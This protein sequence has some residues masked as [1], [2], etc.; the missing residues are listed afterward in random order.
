MHGKTPY[1][2]RD[3]KIAL[4]CALPLEA[5]CVQEVFDKFWEDEGKTYGKAPG[6][7]NVYTAGVIGEHNVVLAYMPGM[8]TISA[9]AAAGSLRVS[10]PNITLAL[11][12]GI[13]GGIPYDSDQEETVLGDVIVSQALI[14]YDIGRQYPGGFKRKTDIRD[15]LG[16]P[17]PEIRAL[18][19][20]LR[21]HRYKQRMQNNITTFLAEIQRELPK[22]KYPGQ[23]NDVLYHSLYIHQHHPPATCN[24]CGKDE[25]ICTL[26]SE[27]ACED[28]RCESH[29]LVTRTRLMSTSI[30]QPTVHFGIMGSG[31]TVMK[32]GQHRDQ[33]A[34]ADG[35]IGFEMEG[36][37][38]WDYFPSIV[39]KGVCDYA[40]SHKRKGWQLYAAATAAACAKAFL[41]EWSV[42]EAPTSS[43]P[44]PQWSVPLERNRDFVERGDMMDWLLERIS[45]DIDK[46][47]CQQTAIEGL[48]GVGKTQMALEAAF[49]FRDRYPECSVFWVT[50]VDIAS[51]ENAYRN[52]GKKLALEGI[53]DNQA[54]VK[55][56]V[57]NAMSQE[58][59]GSWLLIVDN[60]DDMELFF[61]T[62]ALCNY[63]P[64]S[65]QGSILFTSRNHEVVAELDIPQRNIVTITEMTGSEAIQMLRTNLNESQIRDSDSTTALLE[66]LTHLPLAIKQASAYMAKT[67]MSTA[68]Y[69]QHCRS[70]DER[71]IMLLSRETEYQG[72]YKGMN[73]A[74]ATTWLISFNQILRDKPLAADILRHIC[75]LVDKD[76]PLSLF[77][78]GHDELELDEAI[79]T[80]KAYA[81]ITEREDELSFDVHRL[82]QLAMRHWLQEEGQQKQWIAKTVQQ[83]ADIF[84]FPKHENRHL[85]LRYL[86][87]A[88]TAAGFQ[89]V[90][91]IKEEADID[92]IFKI[93][94]SYARLGKHGEAVPRYQLVLDLRTKV[95]GERHF[96]TLVSMNNLA[97]ALE[98]QEEYKEAE[99]IYQRVIDLQK[100]VLEEHLLFLDCPDRFRLAEAL[101]N[102]GRHVLEEQV[103]R[104]VL[105]LKER[106]LRLWRSLILKTMNNLAVIFQ[107]Q[108]KPEEAERM[109]QQILD[110]TEKTLG[111]EHHDTLIS[112]NNLGTV[113]WRQGKLHEAEQILRQT[114]N[115][116][117]KVLGEESVPTLTV[118]NNL[119][120]ILQSQEKYNE[121]EQIRRQVLSLMKEVLGEVHHDTL[122]A[123]DHLG[124]A[125]WLG[126]KHQEA[127]QMLRQTLNL[128]KEVHGQESYS[129]L[130][131]MNNLAEIL[132]SQEKYNEAEQIRRPALS[133]MKKV[134]G[135]EHCDTLVGMNNLIIVLQRQG[136]DEEAQRIK[137]SLPC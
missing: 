11:V 85:W 116:M 56:L 110:E 86:P 46:D 89:D 10:F 44:Q 52:I 103:Q 23:E 112:M 24:E 76:I 128:M 61:G 19:A 125:L 29:M 78:Q 123:M 107:K 75:F 118:M 115:L 127:E 131:V 31:N 1:D 101:Q 54:D 66:L 82:V 4:I 43:A 38:V 21:T 12:V 39:I 122:T 41:L 3:F 32:S 27:T 63:L 17:S 20:K 79:G 73:S 28:L 93:A 33:V 72:R 132:Q 84:P 36:A 49:Q 68:K 25:E 53:E 129:T 71:L 47:S 92:L 98:H 134:L 74:V 42:Q 90:D 15:T 87:H 37:G 77:S 2:R 5:E 64:S 22:T 88:L 60:A 102:P 59:C 57:Q 120:E 45:P 126:G 109:H 119:A 117:R 135:E 7:P 137:D 130:T 106:T 48:G 108:G 104:W 13:C 81:F 70:S 50:A 18:Q 121:A 34:Q 35:I 111:R 65:P 58:S 8:G 55:S 96:L 9:A 69:L 100:E 51:F 113:L 62:M 99:R 30:T 14:Q 83:L 124:G 94:E 67:G 80:L 105:D 16:R 91:D 26:A 97:A 114:L 6:D 95:L 40:D 133:L 136:K